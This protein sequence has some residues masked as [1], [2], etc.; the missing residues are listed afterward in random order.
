M[1]LNRFTQIHMPRS[2][3]MMVIEIFYSICLL[4]RPC[5]AA[6]GTVCDMHAGRA[7]I[8]FPS[9]CSQLVLSNLPC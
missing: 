6:M 3:D 9:A 4:M 8:L 1:R 7:G 2:L 5:H